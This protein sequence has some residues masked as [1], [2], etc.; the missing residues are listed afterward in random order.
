VLKLEAT[1]AEILPLAGRADVGLG[2]PKPRCL[3]IYFKIFGLEPGLAAVAFPQP[4]TQALLRRPRRQP[5]EGLEWELKCSA[6][7]A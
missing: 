5:Q 7:G 4:A 2:T 1:T 3:G 6:R